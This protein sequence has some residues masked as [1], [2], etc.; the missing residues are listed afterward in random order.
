MTPARVD[1]VEILTRHK[2]GHIYLERRQLCDEAFRVFCSFELVTE[3]ESG[4]TA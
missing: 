4:L 1:D 3:D 2:C